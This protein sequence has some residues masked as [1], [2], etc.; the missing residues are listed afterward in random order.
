MV[1]EGRELL[2]P[3][4]TALGGHKRLKMTQN[5]GRGGGGTPE[6]AGMRP[7]RWNVPKTTKD[8]LGRSTVVRKRLKTTQKWCWE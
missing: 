8:G 3:P 7:R 5:Q 4:G 6:R 1:S 2:K